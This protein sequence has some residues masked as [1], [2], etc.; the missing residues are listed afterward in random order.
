MDWGIVASVLVALTLFVA[1]IVT[2]VLMMAGLFV[3]RIKRHVRKQGDAAFKFP[4]CPIMK[5]TQ[6]TP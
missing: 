2:L 4:C 1:A 6:S 5:T 3:W